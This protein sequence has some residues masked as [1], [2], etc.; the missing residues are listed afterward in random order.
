MSFLCFVHR[1]YQN[2]RATSA[3]SSTREK[4][5]TKTATTEIP[6]TNPAIISCYERAV[7][8]PLIIIFTRFVLMRSKCFGSLVVCAQSILFSFF[9]SY[10]NASW[11]GVGNVI[12]TFKRIRNW[13]E[14]DKNYYY[15]EYTNTHTH[16]RQVSTLSAIMIFFCHYSIVSLLLH[17]PNILSNAYMNWRTPI[18]KQCKLFQNSFMNVSEWVCLDECL[19]A[20]CE[21]SWCLHVLVVIVSCF[22]FIFRRLCGQFNFSQISFIFVSMCRMVHVEKEALGNWCSCSLT[23]LA[24]RIPI[25]GCKF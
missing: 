2:V 25:N 14:A 21:L 5:H 22:S 19:R 13:A 12:S 23:T 7:T 8:N 4:C 18:Q 24:I 1:V 20:V 15:F 11:L 9:L 16:L 6:A 17:D 3:T 10:N